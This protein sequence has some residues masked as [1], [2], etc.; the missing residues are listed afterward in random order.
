MT[1]RLAGLDSFVRSEADPSNFPHEQHVYMG[2]ELLRR[3]EFSE[4]AHVYCRALRA[5][6]Q[7]AGKPQVFHQTITIAFLSLIAERMHTCNPADFPDFAA[8]NPDLLDKSVLSR[9]YRPE[10]LAT[11]LARRTFV[12]PDSR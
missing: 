11:D 10:R 2:F 5:M 8:Q 9:W 4:A 12:L 3:Y 1:E 7:R 6:T